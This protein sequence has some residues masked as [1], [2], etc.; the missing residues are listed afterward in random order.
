MNKLFLTLLIACGPLQIMGSGPITRKK[1]EESEQGVAGTI[2]RG[3][4][5]ILGT[6]CLLAAGLLAPRAYASVQ[7]AYKESKDLEW[8]I[9]KETWMGFFDGKLDTDE[10]RVGTAYL[11]AIGWGSSTCA[12]AGIGLAKIFR[13]T[14]LIKR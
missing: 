7:E 8:W 3:A 14:G 6:T 4:D 2:N 12:L 5:I 1:K 9:K 10:K 11:K 13:G